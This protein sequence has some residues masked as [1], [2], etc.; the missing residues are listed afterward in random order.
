MRPAIVRRS[1]SMLTR[2][3]SE[4]EACFLGS[5]GPPLV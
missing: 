1:V 4:G 2:K 3:E 5:D